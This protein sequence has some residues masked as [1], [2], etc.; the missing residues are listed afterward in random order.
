[1]N[2][3]ASCISFSAGRTSI[4]DRVSLE[5]A[6]GSFTA[7]I[8][9]NGAGKSTLLKILSGDLRASSG[10]VSLL[11]RP[12]SSFDA[13]ALS[14]VR[15]VLS[16]QVTIGFPFT[17]GEVIELGL[18]IHNYT[19]LE[20]TGIVSAVMEEAE[21]THLKDRLYSTLSGGEQQRVQ[22][23]R[24]LAQVWE[25]TVYPRFLLLDEPT[26]NL[27]LSHQHA[28]LFAAR[29]MTHKNLG[30]LAIVHDLNLAAQYADHVV[31]MKT[32]RVHAAGVPQQVMTK[33][34][35]EEVFEHPVQVFSM[36]NGKPFVAAMS[37]TNEV[38]IMKQINQ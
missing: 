36:D 19:R 2:L 12:L 18:Y 5:L 16:Q 32:G 30:V 22:L 15:S 6:P 20:A 10:N 17:A 7:V 13:K 29:K 11:G 31:F 9:P 4:L 14:K 28:I 35:I 23:A 37:R 1:M 38:E 21:V 24:A 34:I 26:S 27:D 33:E 8:G 25:D 3:V